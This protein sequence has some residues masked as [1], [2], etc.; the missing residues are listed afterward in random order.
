MSVF[1]QRQ[2]LSDDCSVLLVPIYEAGTYYQTCYCMH[3]SI[4]DWWVHQLSQAGW[5]LCHQGVDITHP[6][7]SWYSWQASHFITWIILASASMFSL[8]LAC[9]R[10]CQR[11][12]GHEDGVSFFR[13]WS[14]LVQ[15][16]N[17]ASTSSFIILSVQVTWF[18]VSVRKRLWILGAS[19]SFLWSS[20]QKFA[21][22][23]IHKLI[24]GLNGF[25]FLTDIIIEPDF[26]RVQ[27][28][29]PHY[30]QVTPLFTVWSKPKM[31]L[32]K[33]PILN[34]SSGDWE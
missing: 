18:L 22:L 13:M 12:C 2:R 16:N 23:L 29:P 6:F 30:H 5:L 14:L 20:K 10:H 21:S 24:L 15:V 4:S 33:N 31:D 32:R 34:G 3:N 28:S 8:F 25:Q 9:C 19:P 26:V 1:L 17:L 27:R 11:W 7:D